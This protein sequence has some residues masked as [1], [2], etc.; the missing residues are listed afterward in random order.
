[1]GGAEGARKKLFEQNHPE[2]NIYIDTIEQRVNDNKD[3]AGRNLKFWID[4][5]DLPIYLL[6]NKSRWKHLFKY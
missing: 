1:M 2:Y 6:L 4:E 5:S 3:Y